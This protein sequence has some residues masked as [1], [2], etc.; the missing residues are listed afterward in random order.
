MHVCLNGRMVRYD[1]ARIAHDDAGLQHGV[2]L[3]ETMTAA[4]GRV[5]RLQAHLERLG[6]SLHEL[7]AAA[8]VDAD[9]LAR[10]VERTLQ[11]NELVEARVRLTV[12]S[13]RLS[14]LA[15]DAVQDTRP[16]TLVVATEP[17]SYDPAWFDHGITVTVVPSIANPF[18]PTCGHKTLAYWG[19]LMTL[20]QAA[21][22]G[23]GEAIWLSTT[24]HLASGS[25]SNIFLAKEGRLQTPF[26]RG[27]EVSGALP[28]PVLPGVTRSAVIELADQMGVGVERRV[29]DI[30]DLLAADEVFL[31]NSSWQILP[32]TRVE[33]KTVG[34][35]EV[36]PLTRKLRTALLELVD[37]ETSVAAV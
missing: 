10:A 31:T 37:R 33:R 28:A 6:R 24:N 23:A 8:A 11:H 35:G 2:G 1:R 27:E 36:G 14:L 20:R 32:V 4:H 7:G 9:L 3:F 12:T 15:A 25:V 17:T 26:A 16:T 30:Q 29:L 22:A 21:A 5:F 18:D 13:G 19:R 34:D